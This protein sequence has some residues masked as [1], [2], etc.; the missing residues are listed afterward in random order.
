MN[1]EFLH[2]RWSSIRMA[3]LFAGEGDLHGTHRFLAGK[4]VAEVETN[5]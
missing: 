2:Y 1:G 3:T 5:I 4:V